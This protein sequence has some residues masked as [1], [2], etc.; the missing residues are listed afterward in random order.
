M[1]IKRSL[2]FL[3]LLLLGIAN[4]QNSENSKLLSQAEEIV[5]YN[6]QETFAIAEHVY[7]N[8]SDAKE[9]YHSKY[10]SA[11][12][13]YVLGNYDQALTFAF[14][15][16]HTAES[17]RNLEYVETSKALIFRIFQFLMLDVESIDVSNP[18]TL[19]IGLQVEDLIRK[20]NGFCLKINWIQP[21][22][23]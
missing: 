18:K 2:S 12:S 8:T 22:F 6:P 1:V 20:S 9:V 3:I 7:K 17:M 14:D 16:K 21:I 11:L 19:E 4:A 15:A 10:L 5:F 23:T 13:N